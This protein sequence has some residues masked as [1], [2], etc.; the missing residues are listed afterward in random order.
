[1][2]IKTVTRFIGGI[3][4]IVLAVAIVLFIVQ[5]KIPLK[6]M[7]GPVS[8]LLTYLS[9]SKQVISGNYYITPGS[10]TTLSI[11]NGF[12]ALIDKNSTHLQAEIKS[13]ETTL[14]LWSLFKKQITLHDFSLHDMALDVT[15]VKRQQRE[16]NEELASSSAKE[17]PFVLN[18]TGPIDLANISA[19][20]SFAEADSPISLQVLKATGEFSSESPGYLKLETDINGN[21]LH[22]EINGGPLRNLT[23]NGAKWPFSIQLMH[24]SVKA[25]V[26]GL[27]SSVMTN[28]ELRAD[29]N[30]SGEHNDDLASLFGWHGT[31]NQ[32]FNIQGDAA[33]SAQEAS[34]NLTTNQAGT[35]DLQL[36]M[37]IKEPGSE[38]SQYAAELKGKQLNLD[39]L[40][41]IFSWHEQHTVNN[42]IKTENTTINRDDD[43]F[44]DFP[45]VKDMKL[46]LN[47]EEMVYKGNIINNFSL[48]AGMKDG[49]MHEAPFSLRIDEAAVSGHFSVNKVSQEPLF[50]LHLNSSDL[51][52]GALLKK[53]ELANDIFS[54]IDNVQIDIS[55]QGKTV[56]QLID[57]FELS[58]RANNGHYEFHDV[59]TGLNQS[60]ML[61]NVT[62]VISPEEAMKLEMQGRFSENTISFSLKAAPFAELLIVDQAWPFS[63]DFRHKSVSLIADGTISHVTEN[64]RLSADLSLSGEDLDELVSLFGVH[65]SLLQP[66]S[67][68][69]YLYVSPEVSTI[70]FTQLQPG[71]D[72][73]TFYAAVKNIE[74]ENSQYTFA[75][76]GNKLNLDAL[77][78]V[79]APL[80]KQAGSISEPSE[81][82]K[83]NR[84]DV[85]L[86]D[87]LPI[88]NMRLDLDLN[89]LVIMGKTMKHVK[90]DAVM[91]DGI[92]DK[93]PFAV[94]MR[95]AVN[96]GHFSLDSINSVPQ[97]SAYLESNAFNIGLFLKE[98]NLAEDIVMHIDHVKADLNTSGHTF[99]E[100]LDNLVFKVKARD[101]FYK[102]QDDNT[103]AVVP[104]T[105]RHTHIVGVPG[106]T[107]ELKLKG[108]IHEIPI[109]IST[110]IK[111][112]RNEPKE[113]VKDLTHF[114]KIQVAGTQWE[115]SGIIPLP[116]KKV[117]VSMSN[118]LSGERLSS[119]NELLHL[120]LPDIGPYNL[121]GTFRIIDSGY[122]LNDI[123][124]QIGSSS[125]TGDLS[126]N[127]K[128]SPPD[129][130]IG[131]QA[132]SI[133]LDDFKEIKFIAKETVDGT[134]TNNLN[135]TVETKQEIF[136]ITDQVILNSYDAVININVKDVS[137][138]TDHLGRGILKVTQHD[139]SLH[140]EPLQVDLPRGNV[141]IDFTIG[142]STQNRFYYLDIL[143]NNID[144]GIA[145]RWFNPDTDIAGILNL[146][147]RLV[148]ESPDAKSIMKN[149]S[150]FI[151]FSIQPV[152]LRS[153]VID[154]W[155]VNLLSRL[156]PFLNPGDESKINCTA[157]R[158]NIENGILTQ[159]ALLLDTSRIRVTGDV[160]TDFHK[161]R[162]DVLLRPVPKRPQFFSLA[163]PITIS[164]SI[165]DYSLGVSPGGVVQTIIRLATS[166]VVVPLQ[167]FIGEGLPVDGTADC[168][169]LF[170]DRILKFSN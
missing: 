106:E 118:K 102:Y 20:I 164:G 99:G 66:F 110:T 135:R 27:F 84:D 16:Q 12:I 155:A 137:S 38:N 163:T 28:P 170:N 48:N 100:L 149:A 35:T 18:R 73:L 33:F 157:G 11:E 75:I 108:K 156:L 152:K 13:A 6:S 125:L 49:L 62:F 17:L 72:N 119:L 145:G 120:E 71:T 21:N 142:P 141:T 116:F 54:H 10:W 111:D 87:P 139:G 45:P 78:A 160:K 4:L 104:I 83:I 124:L 168:M 80:R 14:H 31:K 40:L 63:F 136:N 132:Q 114:T 5:P 90:L 30:I 153:D 130:R 55:S 134:R 57:N 41:N 86:P 85:V 79:I 162:I 56:G 117:G 161:N 8:A 47:L 167:W 81:E 165:I 32:A 25:K 26:K 127:T 51:N 59:D 65:T 128:A 89:E 46:K 44:M 158:F 24:K 105:L 60:I 166:Y 61:D 138:G 140:I 68:Q 58:A 15:S 39:T 123:K 122:Q 74:E 95:N 131:L 107:I 98:Y 9:G 53:L 23:V 129:V 121:N 3:L 36:T 144:Y 93:A 143:V 94:T 50:S 34:V 29:I 52:I 97:L 126:V 96:H 64:P 113:L 169:Q 103:G 82:N 77:K 70:G 69:G 91:S 147:T 151:D 115:L 88:K 19:D 148:S 1:M 2:L 67:L 150:G 22:T 146:R 109:L 7:T 101:G 42:K 37:T 76:Q 92:I 133:Q 159:E 154:L 112:R 43:L